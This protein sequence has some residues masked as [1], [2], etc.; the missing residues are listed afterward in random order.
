MKTL[1]TP[2]KVLIVT[3]CCKPNA[4]SSTADHWAF[5]FQSVCLQIW[6]SQSCGSKAL[7]MSSETKL[8]ACVPCSTSLF[9]SPKVNKTC[10]QRTIS[11][12]SLLVLQA[13]TQDQS[14][15]QQRRRA[16][17]PLHQESFISIP[18]FSLSPSQT[19]QDIRLLRHWGSLLL[20]DFLSP[21]QLLHLHTF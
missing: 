4:T 19:L 11:M 20:L 7:V 13:L 10:W 1:A 21:I 6:K 8:S 18:P 9:H 17:P 14:Q 15:I 5:M 2:D 12:L 3:H 16:S